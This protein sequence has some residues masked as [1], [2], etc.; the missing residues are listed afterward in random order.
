[1]L[2]SGSKPRLTLPVS[3]GLF[4]LFVVT[5]LFPTLLFVECLS[6]WPKNL[7]SVSSGEEKNNGKRKLQLLSIDI[8]NEEP[9]I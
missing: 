9:I 5:P 4:G 8:E 7:F 3:M 2:D 1:M 6:Y